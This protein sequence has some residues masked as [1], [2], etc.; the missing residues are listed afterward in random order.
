MNST[1]LKTKL[2]R[3]LVR[4]EIVSRPYLMRQLDEGFN[5]KLT[6]VSAPAGYGKTT[7][8]SAWASECK[9]PVAWLS[10]D[11]EDNDPVRFLIYVIAAL[12]TTKPNLGQEILSV[13][14]SAQPLAIINLLPELINQLDDIQAHFTL[15]LDDYHSIVSPEIH[16]AITFII[17]HQPPKMHLLLTTRIDPPLHLPK[18]RGRGQLTELR[19][20]DLR[21]SE[22]E[23]LAFLKQG[24]NIELTSTDVNILVN[25][26]EGWIA[27]LQMAALSMR[28]KKDISSFISGFGGS[29]EY[30]VDYFASEILNDLPEQMR[31]F[32]LK[33]SFLDQLCGSLCDEVTGQAGSQLM[34]ER[35]QDANL[36][37]IPLDDE[38]NWY[39]YHQLF[40]DF[41][42]KSLIQTDRTGV[43]EYHLRASQ[44]FEQNEY[45]HLAVEHAFLALDYPRAARLL[46]DVA[47][48]VLGRGEL[49][50]LLKWI[51]K[52]PEDQIE[53]HLR[54]SIIRAVIFV[55]TGLVQEAEEALR[56]I[57]V[58]LQSQA[59]VALTQDYVI[60]RVTAIRAMIA[61]QRGEVDNAK[62]NA[63]MALDK[64]PKGTQREA[65]WR[66]DT[67]T[68]LG[69]SNFARGNL[70]EAKQNLEM[71][72]EEANLSGN[73]FTFLD[74]T[75]YVVEA[76]WIQGC[77]REAEEICQ[78]GL[79]FIDKNNLNSAPMSGEVLLGYCFLLCERLVVSQA[80]DFLKRGTDLARSGGAA[81]VLAWAKYVK[82]RYLIA[83]G[84]LLAADT[85]AREADHLP[86]L[87]G[88]PLWIVSGISSL[89][90]LIW[91]RLGKLDE[92]EEYLRKRGVRTGSKI[93][94]SYQREY[95][96][97]A[98]LLI[99]KGEYKSAGV[100]L[101]NISEWAEATK[102]Y[103]TIICAQTLYSLM[104]AAQKE[105]Q[106][107]LRSLANAM[108]LAEPDGYLLTILELGEEIAPLLYQAIQKGIQP[109][110]ASR[111]LEGLKE[112]LNNPL[113]KPQVQKGE[114]I[115]YTSLRTR[116]I[117]VLK[118]VA[119]GH[120]NKEIA[121]ELHISL[122]TVKFHMTNIL[123]KLGVENRM[124]AV[125]KAKILGIIQ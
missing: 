18:L 65:S 15:I 100:L 14:Q 73:P 24:L 96:S 32:L 56:R 80:E 95:I 43:S 1:L 94:Y 23:T 122:R 7:L 46:E 104:F 91:V 36:F 12:Q 41:L 72:I 2:Y 119:D 64:L 69:F 21:F 9:C 8:V 83:K 82:M 89:K 33:T 6:V 87:S 98:A 78:R 120:T 54:L 13:L 20:A 53:A 61:I 34:L 102:Q 22:E 44:W 125:S 67:L 99:K 88:L 10:L 121:Q 4:P 50:W 29:H 48:L 84:D 19:Q 27:S 76:L 59:L 5:S 118:L 97:L 58:H 42:Y 117:E 85:A 86:Q 74:V 90:V 17:D 38:H 11:N 93:R 111:L 103:R 81:L 108:E 40:A 123:T 116:E 51:E 26:T 63:E 114:P 47:D 71:A 16:K 28:Y 25:R 62:L 37:L 35:L 92:A 105:T 55:S 115:I 39:R 57:E 30:I 3:P 31:L 70:V 106:K 66:A 68:A 112:T 101:D 107:A 110:Y 60:G 109:V 52:L 75:T 77:L 124:Q 49:I 113:A 79:S 45:P